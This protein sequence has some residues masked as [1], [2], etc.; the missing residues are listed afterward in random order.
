[1]EL[2]GIE[3]TAGLP[4]RAMAAS[5][6]IAPQRKQA[7]SS[8]LGAVGLFASYAYTDHQD[9]LTICQPDSSC[10]IRIS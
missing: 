8:R 2:V 5:P 1:M 7:S 4:V 10:F 3:P 6:W 9:F